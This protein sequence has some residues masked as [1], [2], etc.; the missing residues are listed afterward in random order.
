LGADGYRRSRLAAHG[1]TAADHEAL[2]RKLVL[3]QRRLSANK[4]QNSHD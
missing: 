1:W 2:R 3:G 4:A